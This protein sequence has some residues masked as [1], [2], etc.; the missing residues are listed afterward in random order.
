MSNSL[1][2][3]PS[4]PS[5]QFYETMEI[6]NPPAMQ[7]ESA[8]RE[9]PNADVIVWTRRIR[10]H[11][12]ESG[13]SRAKHQNVISEEL[14]RSE[15]QA[16]ERDARYCVILSRSAIQTRSPRIPKTGRSRKRH[17][18]DDA[19]ISGCS[20]IGAIRGVVL[21]VGFARVTRGP[22]VLGGLCRCCQ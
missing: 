8:S 19:R 5:Y 1:Q 18:Y 12:P 20:Q 16:M 4:I 21:L 14:A 15:L 11:Y 7:V 2:A 6:T 10:K 13:I 22:V 17:N 9:E 3:L